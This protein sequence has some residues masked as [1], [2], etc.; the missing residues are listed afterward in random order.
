MRGAKAP[1]FEAPTPK[2]LTHVIQL[3]ESLSCLLYLRK[4]RAL[5]ILPISV[6]RHIAVACSQGR[7]PWR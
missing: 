6:S 7:L 3:L 1:T 5:E 4:S 2:V